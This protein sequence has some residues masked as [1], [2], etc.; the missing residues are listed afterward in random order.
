[1]QIV[2][3]VSKRS[4]RNS[5]T[6]KSA[7]SAAATSW[8]STFIS[9]KDETSALM[10]N[11]S[12]VTKPCDPAACNVFMASFTSGANQP[13]FLPERYM[14]LKRS[15]AAAGSSNCFT[16]GALRSGS[17]G[18]LCAVNNTYA[19]FHASVESHSN[20]RPTRSAYT[21][22]APSSFV[23]KYTFTLIEIF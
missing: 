19:V 5:E 14:H 18:S 11:S 13:S 20:A 7:F 3:T 4:P 23:M 16:Y 9:V 6:A 22:T 1:M 21:E 15:I 8:H 10:L 12:Q 17:S 2:I